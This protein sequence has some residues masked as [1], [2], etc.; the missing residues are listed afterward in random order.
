MNNAVTAHASSHSRMVSWYSGCPIKFRTAFA[1]GRKSALRFHYSPSIHSMDASDEIQM[2]R[3]GST[4]EDNILSGTSNPSKTPLKS[5]RRESPSRQQFRT[6]SMGA[7]QIL[8]TVGSGRWMYIPFS[9]GARRKGIS[10]S[11][12]Q[13]PHFA[14]SLAVIDL[15]TQLLDSQRGD[16]LRS[17]FWEN[18]R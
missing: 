2:A 11:F 8:H 5:A 18:D 7:R 15:A 12:R 9:I 16:K 1:G 4:G 13:L 3:S 17:G 10:R 6:I 14:D